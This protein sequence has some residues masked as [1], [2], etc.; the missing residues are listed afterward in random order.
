M[1]YEPANPVSPAP[2][3]VWSEISFH[4]KPTS[5]N[6]NQMYRLRGKNTVQW[7]INENIIQLFAFIFYKMPF[8]G[9]IVLSTCA[10]MGKYWIWTFCHPLKSICF[11]V[12]PMQACAFLLGLQRQSRLCLQNLIFVMKQKTSHK[13]NIVDAKN[14][15][16][17][18]PF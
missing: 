18:F 6:H 10:K 8:S 17:I 9:L 16:E 15:G 7:R 1:I 4:S 2:L 3:R 13:L 11:C 14:V 5:L 12:T